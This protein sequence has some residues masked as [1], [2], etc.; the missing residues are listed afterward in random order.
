MYAELLLAPLRLSLRTITGATSF[1]CMGSAAQ[2]QGTGARML[3]WRRYDG[4]AQ[5]KTSILTLLSKSFSLYMNVC[6]L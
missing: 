2:D 5:H 4:A 1:S 3:F 6:F